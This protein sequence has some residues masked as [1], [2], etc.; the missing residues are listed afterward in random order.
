MIV[1]NYSKYFPSDHAQKRFLER[2]QL[3]DGLSSFDSILKCIQMGSIILDVNH[4]RY[5]RYHDLFIPCVKLDNHTY[6][7][8]S[9]LT[10]DMV[11]DRIQTVIDNYNL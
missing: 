6:L 3:I 1:F 9:V 8:K 11:K 2:S 10:W 4:H 7:V 5:I